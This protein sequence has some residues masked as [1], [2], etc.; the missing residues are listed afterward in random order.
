ML[1]ICSFFKKWQ[2]ANKEFLNFEQPYFSISKDCSRISRMET[3]RIMQVW[4]RWDGSNKLDS[5]LYNLCFRF[6]V[7]ILMQKRYILHHV[8]KSL[9]IGIRYD[10][11][12]FL[13]ACRNQGYM[14]SSLFPFT[15][16]QGKLCTIYFNQLCRASWDWKFFSL[17]FWPYDTILG[18]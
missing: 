12:T 17:V 9:W 16:I 13:D 8:S 2:I 4:L 10:F 5:L 14:H 1:S 6:E 18:L 15:P 11:K 3:S 7:T